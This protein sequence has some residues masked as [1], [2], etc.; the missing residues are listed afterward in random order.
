MGEYSYLAS[1]KNKEFLILQKLCNNSIPQNQKEKLQKD[2]EE[3]R[4]EIEK[5]G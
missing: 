3:T 4:N 1:L 2:L 5:L